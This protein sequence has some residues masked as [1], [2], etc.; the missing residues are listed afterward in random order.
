MK[1]IAAMAIVLVLAVFWLRQDPPPLATGQLSPAHAGASRDDAA[2]EAFAR[3]ESG[4]MLATNG[5]VDR[6]L[7][8]DRDGSRHQRFILRTD[9]GQTL[10][11]SHNIDLAPR[12]EGLRTGERLHIVGQ[13]EWNERGGLIH[14]THHD[15]DGSHPG[16]YIERQGRRHQ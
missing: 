2:A 14:W 6:I 8:D 5:V 10:L 9:S 13:Y 1:K 7:S 3:R 15:P 12:L 4:R 11:I 16:G